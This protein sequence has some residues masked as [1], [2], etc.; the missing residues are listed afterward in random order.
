MGTLKPD[1][2]Y[3]AYIPSLPGLNVPTRKN[4]DTLTPSAEYTE[5]NAN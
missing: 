1:E 2:Q 5:P 3:H 4:Y